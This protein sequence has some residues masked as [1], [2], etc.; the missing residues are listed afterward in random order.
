V[1]LAPG[2]HANPVRDRIKLVLSKRVSLVLTGPVLQRL[3]LTLPTLQLQSSS[4]HAIARKKWTLIQPRIG[5][6]E[7]IHSLGP[8]YRY[9]LWPLTKDRSAL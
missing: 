7:D 6:I 8:L 4:G 9:S 5:P 3:A 1:V 2:P